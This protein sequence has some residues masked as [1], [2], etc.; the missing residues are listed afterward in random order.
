MSDGLE[1]LKDIVA[2]FQNHEYY[3]DNEFDIENSLSFTPIHDKYGSEVSGWEVTI[4]IQSPNRNTFCGA[5]M[6]NL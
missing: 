3:Q 2:E 4:T 5:P 1:V 6:E